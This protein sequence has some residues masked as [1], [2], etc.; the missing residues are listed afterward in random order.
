MYTSGINRSRSG[1]VTVLSVVGDLL[2]LS[3]NAFTGMSLARLLNIAHLR[4]SRPFFYFKAR[5]MHRN[6]T[7]D[8]SPPPAR[9]MRDTLDRSAFH[10]TVP[11]LAAR[12]PTALTGSVLKAEPMRGSVPYPIDRNTRSRG[13]SSP[14]LSVP[15]DLHALP[16]SQVHHQSAKNT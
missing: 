5:K 4:R 12:L 8:T 10:R 1:M 2:M 15:S 7:I 3:P 11:V 13:V 6:I 14:L 9:W 16:T